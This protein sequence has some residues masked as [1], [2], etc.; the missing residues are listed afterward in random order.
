MIAPRHTARRQ[1][2]DRQSKPGH[3]VRKETI[4]NFN[5]A[6]R[7]YCSRPADERFTSLA[8]Y[9]ASARHDKAYSAEKT[10]NTRDLQVIPADVPIDDAGT[11]RPT[12]RLQSPKGI[13]EFTH[14]SFGQLAR[15][16]GAPANYLRELPPTIAADALNWAMHDAADHAT[17]AKLLVKANGSTPI[18]RACTSETYGRVWDADLAEPLAS[19]LPNFSLPP[20]WEKNPDGSP[21]PTGAFRG[22]RDSFLILVDGGSIVTDP[23][24]G[25]NNA[26]HRGVMVRNS[27]TGACSIWIDLIWFRTVCGNLMITGGMYDLRF[28]RRHVGDHARRDALRTVYDAA[29]RWT[30][31]PA[32]TDEAIVRGLIQNEIAHTKEAVIDELRK[33]KMTQ[34]DAIAAYDRAVETEKASPRSYWGIANGITRISQD[35]GFQD[36]RFELDQ[37]A[38]AVLQRGR[39]LVAA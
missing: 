11:I 24:A 37:I 29:H 12:L 33:L 14:W 13:A 25:G 7:E 22:D 19:H 31:R 20:S 32:S 5:T 30:D 36:Q 2:G 23:S 9:L 34:A 15:M 16:L 10:Y 27:E 28:R 26:M 8:T 35:S 4:V 21:V 1:N 17:D 3:S 6:H 38:A 18:V 39:K